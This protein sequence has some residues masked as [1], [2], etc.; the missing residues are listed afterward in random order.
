MH[1]GKAYCYRCNPKEI[2]R[3]ASD[4]D[5]HEVVITIDPEGMNVVCRNRDSP[6]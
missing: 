4:R 2:A 6:V 3:R 5:D 1:D